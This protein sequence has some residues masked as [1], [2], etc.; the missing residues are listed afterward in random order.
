MASFDKY[1]T[2]NKGELWM[3]KID[4]GKDPITGERKTTTRRGFKTL[5]EAKLA[6]L[7]MEQEVINGEYQKDSDITFGEFAKKW[8]IEYK[9]TVKISTYDLRSRMVDI[10]NQYF[11]AVK[12]SSITRRRYK[13]TLAKI[14]DSY[15]DNSAS[16]IHSTASLIFKLALEDNII[17]EDPTNN[18]RIIRQKESVEEAEEKELPKY[19]E[20]DELATFLN[21]AKSKLSHQ[22]YVIFLTLA[23]TGM[24]IGEL[25]AIKWKDVS[26]EENT[27]SITKTCYFPKNNSKSFVLLPPKTKASKREIIVD[28]M[29][30]KELKRH[31]FNQN[32]IKMDRAS[33][34]VDHDFVFT[35]EK[36]PGYPYNKVTIEYKMKSL[37]K[38]SG[39]EKNLSPHSL[40]HTHVS[41]LA[42]AGA[43][44]TEIME[45]VGHENDEVTRRIYLH[46]TKTKKERAANKF[47]K[48]MQGVVKPWSQEG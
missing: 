44:I 47:S 20:K 42:E 24:R 5:R 40:R 32:K 19:L 3:F 8:L 10:L 11:K 48:L 45:R 38:A 37:L 1:K 27:I 6:A 13:D 21:T 36:S 25:S 18:V 35:A 29:I 46:V 14:Q 17:K 12:I 15:S 2:K 43:D 31:K 23:Y 7:Q 4:V 34:Y 26:F 22:D 33:G 28:E 30:I 16:I 39:I 9:P 41:L